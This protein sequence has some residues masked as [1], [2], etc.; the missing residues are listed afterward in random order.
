MFRKDNPANDNRKN[1]STLNAFITNA[2][3]QKLEYV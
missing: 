1:G 3:K 2:I